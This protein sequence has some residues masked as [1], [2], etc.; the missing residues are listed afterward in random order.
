[1]FLSRFTLTPGEAALLSAREIEV[2]AAL[3]AAMDKVIRIRRDCQSL[4]AFVGEVS[5]ISSSG[6]GG[7]HHVEGSTEA[8][9]AGK[10]IMAATA[11][12]LEA[13]YDKIHRWCEFEFRKYTRDASLEVSPVMQEAVKRLLSDRDRLLES[14]LQVLSSTR[15]SAVSQAFLDA[16]TKGGPGGMPRPIELHAH[17]PTRYVGDMLAWIHQATAGE[18]EFLDALLDIRVH[19]KH[20]VGST[21]DAGGDSPA[22]VLGRE[23]LDKHLEGLARPLKVRAKK[24]CVFS[25]S[26]SLMASTCGTGPSQAGRP[27][28]GRHHRVLQDC[29]SRAILPCHHAAHDRAASGSNSKLARVRAHLASHRQ[30]FPLTRTLMPA[31]TTRLYPLSNQRCKPEVGVCCASFT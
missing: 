19:A 24:K 29:E 28:S 21:R 26:T 3:F 22:E 25:S 6:G 13:A 7:D 5:S 15:Q 8:A 1:M 2:D 16:L 12:Q 17:D 20:M 14:A 9:L 30:L 27:V 4:F 23:S 11:D 31:C 18:R 10:E